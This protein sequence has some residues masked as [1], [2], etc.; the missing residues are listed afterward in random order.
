MPPRTLRLTLVAL[1]ALLAWGS[2]S[3]PLSAQA[4]TQARQAPARPGRAG[5]VWKVERQGRVGWLVGSLH[6]LPPDAYPLPA[7]MTDAFA[8]SDT[9]ME[10]ADLESL[11]SPEFMAA[12]L[13]RAMF[14]DGRT[15]QAAISPATFAAVAARARRAGLPVEAL[16]SM[17]PWM[18]AMT[19]EALELQTGGFDAN[20]G[21]DKHFYDEAKM[22][23]L[24]FEPLETGLEQID[25]LDGLSPADQEAMLREGLDASGAGAGSGTSAGELA[26]LTAAWKA[27]DARGLEAIVLDGTR[28]APGLYDR[29]IVAR[30]QRW[31]PTVS[32]CLD[33]RRCFVVV[34]AAHLVGPDGLVT[35]LRARG[36][37]VTQQ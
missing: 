28:S 32:T 4:P 15:L 16:Q 20:L 27:G 3:P 6:L 24:R 22:R 10:E 7:V 2:G 34:G 11:T 14:L 9:L 19:L 8:A 12:V 25:T 36:Y 5:F 31:L 18:V 13:P 37:T 35:S 23:R 17:K 26:R 33:T 21:L 1:A 29:V 30:N